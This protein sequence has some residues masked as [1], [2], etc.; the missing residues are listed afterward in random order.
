MKK[1]KIYNKVILDNGV[2]IISIPQK[3]V[4]SATIFILVKTGSKY[5]TKNISG[6]SHFLEHMFFKGTDKM[7]R[8][9]DVAEFLDRIGGSFNAFTG[10]EMTGYYAKTAYTHFDLAIDWV[11]DIF[12]NSKFPAKEMEKER[13]VIIEEINMYE[14]NPMTHIDQV[15]KEVLYGDQPAGWD[16]AGTK[17]TVSNITRKEIVGY[18]KDRYK[19]RNIVVCIAGNYDENVVIDKIRSI[20]SVMKDDNALDKV[21]VIE[22]QEKPEIKLCYRKINQTNLVIGVRSYNQLDDRKYVI[23]VM[24]A[25]LGGMMSSRLFDKVREKMGA[26][27]HIRTSNDG[28]TDVGNFSASSGVDNSKVFQVIEVILK[29][30]NRLKV[31]KVGEA[32]LRKAKDY[33]KGKTLLGFESIESKI[34]F[35]GAQELLTDKIISIEDVLEK[36]ENVTAEDIQEAAKDIFKADKLN[37]AIIGPFKDKKEFEKILKI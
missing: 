37:L 8:P 14:D 25:F 15:W 11:S 22:K 9:I 6:I 34:S 18:V 16:I 27:Y 26:A 13:G 3:E 20:F 7:K 31:E 1:N 2:R 32:E 35:C 36:I 24:S 23:D 10:E 29:E 21:P 5:E 19:T 28:D 30:F 4:K 12:L 17:E 33:I